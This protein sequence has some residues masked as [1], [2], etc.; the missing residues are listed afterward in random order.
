M[1][2]SVT[3]C[4]NVSRDACVPETEI[5]EHFD[6]YRAALLVEQQRL[7]APNGAIIIDAMGQPEVR[8]E[9]ELDY[10]IYNLCYDVLPDLLAGARVERVYSRYSQSLVL[11]ATGHD[12]VLSGDAI[13]TVHLDLKESVQS[14]YAC[15]MR[16]LRFLKRLNE[17]TD[18][19]GDFDPISRRA[20]VVRRELDSAFLDATTP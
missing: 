8:I 20:E 17:G 19:P 7:S 3:F 14:F 15:G 18:Y 11:D 16:G 12:L 5:G 10:W 2:I 13:P 1:P 9:D 6:A 4:V